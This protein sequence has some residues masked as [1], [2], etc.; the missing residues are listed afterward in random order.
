MR[1]APVSGAVGRAP[2][3]VTTI[4]AA[5]EAPEGWTLPCRDW[6]SGPRFTRGGSAPGPVCVDSEDLEPG[7]PGLTDAGGLVPA[8]RREGQLGAKAAISPE[9]V[10]AGSRQ[11]AAP[12]PIWRLDPGRD[13]SPSQPTRSVG[14]LLPLR[15]RVVRSACP[16]TRSRHD[17]EMERIVVMRAA[18]RSTF[19]RLGCPLASSRQLRNSS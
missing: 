7:P 18:R 2:K 9:L 8:V 12:P 19:R 5:Y 10:V 4:W 13:D 17:R 6:A 15:D 11:Y 1:R 14:G 3:P 16:G